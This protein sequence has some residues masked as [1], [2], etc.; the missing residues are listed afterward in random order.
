MVAITTERNLMCLLTLVT[1]EMMMAE[2]DGVEYQRRKCLPGLMFNHL[3][4]TH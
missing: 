2:D 3:V 1:G 4:C